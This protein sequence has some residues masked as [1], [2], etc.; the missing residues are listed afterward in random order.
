MGGVAGLRHICKPLQDLSSFTQLHW[1]TKT[2]DLACGVKPLVPAILCVPRTIVLIR[3]HWD[4]P[5]S[6]RVYCLEGNGLEASTDLVFLSL[7]QVLV[8]QSQGNG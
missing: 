4:F 6:L 8:F 7:V 5:G 2:A 3:T 1:P